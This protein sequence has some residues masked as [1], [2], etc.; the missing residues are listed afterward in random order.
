MAKTPA[1]DPGT[2]EIVVA[3]D[4]VEAEDVPC[5]LVAVTVNVYE[6]PLVRPVTVQLVSAP[7]LV[8]HVWPAEEVTVY[9]VIVAPP[10]LA[11]AVQETSALPPA[12]DAP[13]ALT[14]VGDAGELS[15]VTLLDA[16]DVVPV[17]WPFVAVTVK[18]YAVPLVRPCTVQL[19]S[20]PLLVMHVW[21]PEEVT[22]YLVI[23]APPLLAGAVQ[24][25]VTSP[26]P[27]TDAVTAVGASGEVAGVTALDS[28]EAAPVPL[29]FVAVTV[30]V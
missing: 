5:T 23:V 6:E 29:A 26:E 20:A 15:G 2:P 22:V 13:A 28:A 12:T 30:K 4:A 17:P 1:G 10:L 16:E 24:E 9:L 7:V 8:V 18:V 3:L 27:A 14:A 25:T 21:P 19:V 11:G